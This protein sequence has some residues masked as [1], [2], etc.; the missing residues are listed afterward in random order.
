MAIL[1]KPND[2]LVEFL[3][4]NLTDPRSRYT[5]DSD[6]FTATSSQ[7]EFTLTPAT[8]TH[9]VRAIKSVKSEGT[10]LEKWGEYDVNLKGKQIVLKTGSTVGDTVVVAYYSSASGDEWI[11]P[12]WPIAKM[13]KTKFPRISVVTINKQGDR[14]GPYDSSVTHTLHF[15]IDCWTKEPYSTTIDGEFYTEAK[16]A[17]YLSEQVEAELITNINEL[18]PKLYDY[19]ELAFGF[20]PFEEEPQTFRHKQEFT[21]SGINVGH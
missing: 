17:E 10:T 1:K 4:A 19:S 21:L 15:Q 9:L 3:R 7:T 20:A 16:L 18:Y 2:I 6:T 14:N 5:A 8:S 11:Y 12:D 13:G